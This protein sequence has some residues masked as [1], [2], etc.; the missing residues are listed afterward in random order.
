[1]PYSPAFSAIIIYIIIILVLA[2]AKPDFIYDHKNNKFREFGFTE[3]KS[4]ITIITLGA[5]LSFIIY[6]LVIMFAPPAPIN[7]YNMGYSR[8]NYY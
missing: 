3:G 8:F 7:N 4:V 2:I 6:N 1:M 5:V